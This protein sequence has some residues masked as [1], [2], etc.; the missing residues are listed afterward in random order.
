MDSIQCMMSNFRRE[1]DIRK[2]LMKVL[3]MKNPVAEI[4]NA[5][6]N[7]SEELTQSQYNDLEDR[8]IEIIQIEL[9]YYFLSLGLIF[10]SFISSL[11]GKIKSPISYLCSILDLEV[12]KYVSQKTM[13][14]QFCNKLICTLV[15]N[16]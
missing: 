5:F 2:N 1:V 13:D 16:K 11:K 3:Q 15:L 7:S 10:S 9:V 4:R 12:D 14:Y 6:A 8:H